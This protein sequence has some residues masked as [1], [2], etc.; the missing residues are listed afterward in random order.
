M[1]GLKIN[2][3]VIVKAY[4]STYMYLCDMLDMS[5]TL[6]MCYMRK[7]YMHMHT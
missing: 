3:E 1:A 6:L 5:N 7:Q 2:L 4:I